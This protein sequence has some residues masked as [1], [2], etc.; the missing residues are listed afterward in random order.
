MKLFSKLSHSDRDREV[1]ENSNRLCSAIRLKPLCGSSIPVFFVLHR[2]RGRKRS[3][4]LERSIILL[5]AGVLCFGWFLHSATYRRLVLCWFP[6]KDNIRLQKKATRQVVL[7]LN[8]VENAQHDSFFSLKRKAH[9]IF[10]YP[11]EMEGRGFVFV[12]VHWHVENQVVV[13][14]F[15]NFLTLTLLFYP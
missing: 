14:T 2:S 8:L 12:F 3:L 15:Y 5:P 4:R 1:Q 7:E 11:I 13:L 9:C 10:K 6:H